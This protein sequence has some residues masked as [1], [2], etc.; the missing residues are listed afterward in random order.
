MG[1]CVCVGGRVGGVGWE[2]R[3]V[4]V[5]ECVCVC[6]PSVEEGWRPPHPHT[7]AEMTEICGVFSEK[8][9]FHVSLNAEFMFI[10]TLRISLDSLH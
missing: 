1:M 2:S 4:Y 9:F 8:H 6:C 10:S 7:T 5:S 3:W